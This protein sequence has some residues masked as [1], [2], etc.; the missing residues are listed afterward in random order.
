MTPEHEVV[1]VGAGFAGLA[2]AMELEAAGI[3][4]VVILERA[5]DVGGTWRENT[6]PGVACD[7]PAHLYALARHPWSFAVATATLV[8]AEV[9]GVAVEDDEGRWAY[10]Y[11]MPAGCLRAVLVNG[12]PSITWEV[13][14]G[15]LYCDEEECVLRYLTDHVTYDDWPPLFLTYV[16]T[17]LA[18][19]VAMPI[20]G[21]ADIARAMQDLARTAYL[22][23]LRDDASGSRQNPPA[24]RSLA[25]SRF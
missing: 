7:V 19:R 11:A 1:I 5:G 6:S 13:R 4:D 20:T 16:G 21:S 10:A 24:F 12:D 18:A 8:A 25:D 15:V 17:L 2:A 22:S 14:G 23:A 3:T 9:G